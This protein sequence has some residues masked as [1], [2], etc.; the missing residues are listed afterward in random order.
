MSVTPNLCCDETKN[1]GT[2]TR[3]TVPWSFMSQWRK[4]FR[5]SKVIDKKWFIRIGCLWGLQATGG[6]SCPKNLL[7]YGIIIKG[8]VERGRTSLS[9]L[10]RRHASIIS[11]SSRLSRGVFLSLRGSSRSTNYCCFFCVQRACPRDHWLTDFTGQVVG[12]M[13]PLFYCFGACLV[14]LLH[15]FVAKKACLFYG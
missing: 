1:Q 12:L 7:S 10:S 8:K 14:L 11:S 2:Y 3:V 13:P 6:V 9:F 5:E 4:E 15:G